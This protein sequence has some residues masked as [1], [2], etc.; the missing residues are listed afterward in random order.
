[1]KPVKYQLL[2][3]IQYIYIKKLI[4]SADRIVAKWLV[5]Y[6]VRFDTFCS[7]YALQFQVSIVCLIYRVQNVKQIG[8]ISVFTNRGALGSQLLLFIMFHY[9]YAHCLIIDNLQAVL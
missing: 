8:S 3:H 7:V 6:R 9:I 5:Y 2:Q 1:V 4:N